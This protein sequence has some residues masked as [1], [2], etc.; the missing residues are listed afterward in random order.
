MS[1]DSR[2]EQLKALVTGSQHMLELAES[3]DWEGV[4]RLQ[5]LRQ[6]LAEAYFATPAGSHEVAAIEAAVRQILASDTK[7]AA[8]GREQRDHCQDKLKE[9]NQRRHA[10]RQYTSNQAPHAESGR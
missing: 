2:A 5:E 1:A 3:S 10:A 9:F 6:Q 7:I 8:L 4:A